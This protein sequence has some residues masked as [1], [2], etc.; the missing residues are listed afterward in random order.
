MDVYS[1]Y[2]LAG[3]RRDDLVRE[4]E[5]SRVARLARESRDESRP[6]PRPAARSARAR[7]LGIAR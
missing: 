5:E 4:A 2:A 6:A 7:R 3:T 1:A